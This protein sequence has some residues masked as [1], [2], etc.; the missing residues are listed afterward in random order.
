M[1]K[2]LQQSASSQI[3][4]WHIIWVTTGSSKGRSPVSNITQ[5]IKHGARN[6][7][8][9][10]V[11]LTV[12]HVTRAIALSGIKLGIDDS[13]SWWPR[14]VWWQYVHLN[15]SGTHHAT[16]H[17]DGWPI[18]GECQDMFDAPN[19]HSTNVKHQ[20]WGQKRQSWLACNVL[21]VLD[22]LVRRNNLTEAESPPSLYHGVL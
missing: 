17:I 5:D 22:W 7:S 4:R 10:K 13:W 18:G 16:I 15:S 14:Q 2:P 19:S 20:F 11:V 12:K 9:L 1:G 21:S 6:Y 8:A 3:T